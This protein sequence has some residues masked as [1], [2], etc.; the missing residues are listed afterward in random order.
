MSKKELLVIDIL[1]APGHI[2][3]VKKLLEILDTSLAVTFI[4]SQR[5]IDQ[6]GFEKNKALENSMFDYSG[7]TG[8]V[9]A[10]IQVIN[11]IKTIIKNPSIPIILTGFENI[12][13]SLAWKLK[14][15]TYA[16]LHN[17]LEKSGL[18]R[19][20]LFNISKNIQFIAFEEYIVSY[21]DQKGLK[22][23][24]LPHPL[25]I[26]AKRGKQTIL[27]TEQ[28][29]FAPHINVHSNFFK[30]LSGFAI[31]NQ[32]KLY[33]R[34]D[35]Q[36]N[37]PEHIIAKPYFNDY[38][39]LL[40]HAAFVALNISY[41]YRVSGIFYEAMMLNKIIIFA[42]ASYRFTKEMAIQ[43]PENV[44]I[45]NLD[46]IKNMKPD[47]TKFLLKHAD[48]TLLNHLLKIIYEQN[49]NPR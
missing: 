10:Q 28:F 35:S 13:F 26:E 31:K 16:L 32:L 49:I 44:C 36:D 21:M 37:M 46:A 40:W 8:F 47:N 38:E 14:N 3:L 11:A 17:N 30:E 19:F 6:I 48:T 24:Y 45:N 15:P 42:E 43:Y 20:F 5:Y 4:S 7:R 41:N 18:S 23:H 2:K 9:K 25:Q 12:S 22:G 34:S 27:N 29:I 33:I 1:E 39:T